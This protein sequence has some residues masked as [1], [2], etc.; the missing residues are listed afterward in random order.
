MERPVELS[1][2]ETRPG[3]F[4]ENDDAGRAVTERN[5][6]RACRGCG[7]RPIKFCVSLLQ[8]YGDAD[9]CFF[10]LDA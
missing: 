5:A 6:Q 1:R 7:L 10:L 9:R 8:F 4:G 3:G 2:W